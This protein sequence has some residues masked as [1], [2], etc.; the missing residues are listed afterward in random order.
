MKKLS[1]ILVFMIG[2]L[3]LAGCSSDVSK[4]IVEVDED[5]NTDATSNNEVE[6]TFDDELL[7]ESDEVE[8][9]ELI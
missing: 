1:L 8:I 5:T 7:D 9:G 2:I 3:F 6:E 4:S